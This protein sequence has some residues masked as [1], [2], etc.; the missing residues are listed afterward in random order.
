MTLQVPPPKLPHIALP[1]VRAIPTIPH[2]GC[3]GA[4]GT[5]Y[6]GQQFGNAPDI[7][8]A[9]AIKALKKALEEQIY[10]LLQ[11]ELPQPAR[12]PIYAARAAQ[13]A[14]E[15]ADVVATLNDLIAGVTAETNAAISFVN[16]TIAEVNQAQSTL[17]EI[18]EG[19]RDVVQRVMIERYTRYAGELTA[20]AARLG[21]TIECI[22]A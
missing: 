17:L 3:A 15:V 21:T 11:G 2:V 1:N 6:V 19:A 18:P 10:A 7:G 4:Q 5:T 22:S 20:Q 8:A 14:D 9:R 13:L 16:D 12:A